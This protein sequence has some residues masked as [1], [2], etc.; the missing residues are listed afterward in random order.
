MT[1]K[2]LKKRKVKFSEDGILFDSLKSNDED[3]LR[4]TLLQNKSKINLNWKNPKG[5]L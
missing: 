5:N 1:Q 4:R 2:I 3:S